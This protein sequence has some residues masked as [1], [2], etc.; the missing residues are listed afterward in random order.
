MSA[1]QTST[2]LKAAVGGQQDCE[3]K[4][5]VAESI[6]LRL[7]PRRKKK[8]ERVHWSKDV[9]E[10]NEFSGKFKSKKCCQFHKRR[11]FGEWSDEDDSDAECQCKPEG[12]QPK[13]P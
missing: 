7:V 4:A 6:T 3:Q 2:V 10:I 11:V 5:T 9:Q 8:D 13:E 12:E 1:A